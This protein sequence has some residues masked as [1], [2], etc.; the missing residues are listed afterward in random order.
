M[1]FGR[2]VLAAGI[3]AGLANAQ[4]RPMSDWLQSQY[5]QLRTP[6]MKRVL[7]QAAIAGVAQTPQQQLQLKNTLRTLQGKGRTALPAWRQ[8]VEVPTTGNVQVVSIDNAFEHETNDGWKW[9]DDMAGQT[10]SGDCTAVE[11]VD[12]WRYVAA[13]DGFY[14]FDVNAA[15]AFPIADSWLTLRNHKGD[16]IATNDN[17]FPAMSS[18]SIFLPA[19]TY[20]LEVTGYLGTGG[21]TYDLV[22]RRDDVLVASLSSGG[23]GTT[24]LPASAAVHDVFSFT[25]PDSNVDLSVSSGLDTALRIQR[26]DGVV[27]FSNDDSTVGGLDAAADIDLPAGQYYAYVSEPTGGSGNAYTISYAA[28]P[29]VFADLATAGSV[30]GDL[31]GNESMRLV[32]IDLTDAAHLDMATSD[33][34]LNPVLD[35]N[36]ALLDRDLDYVL[37]VEDDD[38]FGAEPF[39]SRIAMSLPAGVYWAAVT[40]YIGASGDYTLAASV[41]AYAPNGTSPLGMMTTSIAG[42]GD[43]NTYLIDNCSPSSVQ[44]RGSDFYFGILGPDGELATNTRCGLLQPQAGELPVGT[45]T[46]FTWD[47]FDY[48]ATMTTWVI[49]PLHLAA[50]GVTVSTRAKEGDEVWVFANFSGLTAGMN[51]GVGDSGLFCLPTDSLLLTLGNQAVP[52]TGLNAW[53]TLPIGLT[54]VDLQSADLHNGIVWPAPAWASWRNAFQ[55]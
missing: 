20:Y 43:V 31:V 10:A 19:G 47:R 18:I 45:S 26:A 51:F 41:G 40:P 8:Q 25:V 28:A 49:P 1:S 55:F 15:G 32:R 53:F 30:Q 22:A 44:V 50:D 29:V 13:T 27:V 24:Q 5:P 7:E 48:S 52:A 17:S 42:F 33:G 12:C 34:P 6:S 36:L 16:P 54:G 37:D 21:G 46:L 9:A 11:D 4:S 35:T 39:Y 23:A 38:P 14:T 2:F 3:L